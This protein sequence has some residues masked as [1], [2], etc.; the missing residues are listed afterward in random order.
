MTELS[1]GGE[2]DMLVE[3]LVYYVAGQLHVAIVPSDALDVSLG[4]LAHGGILNP[5]D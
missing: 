1:F 3:E 5:Q 2:L 4:Q